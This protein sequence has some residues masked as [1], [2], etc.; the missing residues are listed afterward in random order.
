MESE[1]MRRESG[2]G[3]VRVVAVREV[4]AVEV[5]VEGGSASSFSFSSPIT[6]FT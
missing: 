3:V 5:E 1:E 2:G 6:A 4:S